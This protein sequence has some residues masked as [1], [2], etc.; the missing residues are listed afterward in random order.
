M[1]EAMSVNSFWISINYM[2]C[3]GTILQETAAAQS[4][5]YPLQSFISR[6]NSEIASNDVSINASPDK[7][8]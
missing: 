2:S 8:D 3:H 6:V 7:P 5:P 4:Q 1:R